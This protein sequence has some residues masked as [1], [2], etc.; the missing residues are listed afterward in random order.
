MLARSLGRQAYLDAERKRRRTDLSL[1]RN[2]FLGFCD[3]LEIVPKDGQRCT[4]KP[5]PAQRAFD[6][7]RTGRDIVLKA[8]QVGF[9]T[10]EQAR[11]VWHFLTR[12]GARVV[13]TCQSL[14]D[15]GPQKNLS[16]N[17]QIFFESLRNQGIKLKFSTETAT[18]WELGDS[19]LV[20]EEA[21]ASEAAASKKGRSGRISRL[22]LTETAFYEYA[23]ETLNAMLECVSDPSTGSEIVSESTPNGAAG[24]FFEQCQAA[25]DGRSAY[26]FHFLPWF[27]H[28]E[29]TTPPNGHVVE[30]VTDRERQLVRLGVT[31]GQLLWFRHKV[32][33]KT[34][35]K[36]DQ[37]YPTDP[38][39]CFLV[40]GR[41]FFD[42]SATLKLLAAATEPVSRSRY[43]STWEPPKPGAAYVISAD[44][45]EGVG[46]DFSGATVYERGTGRHVATL[47][48]Q[49]APWDFA[50]ELA[51]L[52][53]IYNGA[54]IVVERNNHGHAVLQALLREQKY[55]RIFEGR[56]GR[57]GWLTNEVTRTAALDAFEDAHRRGIWTSPDAVVLGEMLK[58]IINEKGKAEAA[59]GAFDDMVIASAIGW[60][61]LTKP[62]VA[63]GVMDQPVMAFG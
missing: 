18:R 42:R 8:R 13:A 46:G 36:A 2:D 9:T 60:D 40:S 20:I 32:A 57:P 49:L 33:D 39:T 37:E 61:A 4:F 51:E 58:F 14:T 23:D 28:P 59:R 5:W 43:V 27:A 55:P 52:G 22:H 17:F 11:D 24:L 34:Q 50:R 53:R 35:D 44:P 12:P 25:R 48:G 31:P 62:G 7:A 6:A 19:T 15:H 41:T 38:E 26:R 45:A 1:Y 63:R 47:R 10:F 29:Y 16:K 54:V 30:P 21:G 56:D 3:L